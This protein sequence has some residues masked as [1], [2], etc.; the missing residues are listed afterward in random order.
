MD[1]AIA[2][3]R[4]LTAGGYFEFHG[5]STTCSPSSSPGA[6]RAVPILIGGHAD[7]RPAAG[8]AFG[9]GWLHG[10]GDP[11]D[12][13]GLLTRLPTAGEEGTADKPFEVHVISLDAFTVDGIH[14]LEEPG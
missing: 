12:L 1:E 9:D 6:D 13:P 11:A 4:G 5:E 7:A 3:M 10:G 8:G 2:I 14:R